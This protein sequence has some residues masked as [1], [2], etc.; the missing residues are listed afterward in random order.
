MNTITFGELIKKRRVAQKL[1][2]R[3][4][5][6]AIE[7]DQSLLSKIERNKI[8]APQRVIKPL[9]KC[10]NIGYKKLQ[11]KY[12]SD[13]LYREFKDVDFSVESFELTIKQLE[14]QGKGTTYELEKK[15]FIR[16]INAYFENKPVE[17]AWLFGSFARNQESLDSDIDVLVRFSKPNKIDLFDYIG[18]RQDLEDLTGRQVDLV[19]EGHE[20]EKIKPFIHADKKLIYE[21]KAIKN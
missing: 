8:I 20:S 2:L 10:L 9:A 21:R 13:K 5:A 4:V 6:G 14:T 7:L 3:E 15:Q 19:E 18:I 16:K 11:I 1:P 12:L 17:K